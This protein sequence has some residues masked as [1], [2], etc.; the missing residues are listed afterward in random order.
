MV[1]SWFGVGQVV[2]RFS[3]HPRCHRRWRARVMDL[4][5][6]N[7]RRK[8]IEYDRFC[9]R[10]KRHS[11][12]CFIELFYNWAHNNH[13]CTLLY[14]TVSP[15]PMDASTDA[16]SWDHHDHVA[17]L[18]GFASSISCRAALVL[19]ARDERRL[20]SKDARGGV[21]CLYGCFSAFPCVT[22]RQGTRYNIRVR[23]VS[24]VTPPFGQNCY[25]LVLT[26][27]SASTNPRRPHI[28]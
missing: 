8:T 28:S 25:S 2:S 14:H 19:S 3:P 11:S 5:K 12:L 23:I 10:Q 15:W 9:K 16:E 22:R 21:W 26:P 20:V 24:C 27:P 7:S 1:G 18:G 6:G 17:D 4:L 13:V